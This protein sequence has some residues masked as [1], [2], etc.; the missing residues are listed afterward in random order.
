[1]SVS[2]ATGG[3]LLGAKTRK[4]KSKQMKVLEQQNSRPKSI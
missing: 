4:G 3:K 1:M 2:V